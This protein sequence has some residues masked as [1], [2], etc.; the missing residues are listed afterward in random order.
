[1][2]FT[3]PE[4]TGQIQTDGTF[5]LVSKAN[6]GI[7]ATLKDEDVFVVFSRVKGGTVKAAV[8]LA[9][10]QVVNIKDLFD[11]LFDKYEFNG[12]YGMIQSIQ[13]DSVVMIA[14]DDVVMLE[15]KALKTAMLEFITEHDT[16][17]IPKGLHLRVKVPLK[18]MHVLSCRLASPPSFLSLPSVP[19]RFQFLLLRISSIELLTKKR[20]GLGESIAFLDITK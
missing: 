10:T 4:I 3:N 17:S 8:V 15:N 19:P 11:F 14:Q 16:K 7:T 6:V 20:T 12:K 2:Q 18:G 5:Q 1:M 13:D 9:I